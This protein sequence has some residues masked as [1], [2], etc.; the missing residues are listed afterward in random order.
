MISVKINNL[1]TLLILLN[2]PA[3]GFNLGI[4]PSPLRHGCSQYIP[5]S[6]HRCIE[7]STPLFSMI[8]ENDEDSSGFTV[9]QRL[10]EEVE[11]PFRKLRLY[12]FGVSTASALLALYFSL[13][14]ALKASVGGFAD[15]QPLEEALNSCGINVAAVIIC[16]GITYRDVK[17]GTANLE[18]IAKGGALAKLGVLS[19]ISQKPLT[20]S[21]YRR[22]SRVL[23]AVGGPEYIAELARSLNSDQLSD[24]NT[25]ASKIGEVDMVIVPVLLQNENRV[26][27]TLACWQGTTAID[28]RDRNFDISRSDEVLAFPNGNYGWEQYLKSEIETAKKQGFDVLGKGLTLIVKKNGRILRRTTG[29]PNWANFI[30]TMEV[31]DGSKFGMPGDTEKYG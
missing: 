2:F 22:N 30:G 9:K 18:R 11:S 24:N 3:N 16:G 28:G 8:P 21:D 10:R 23:I 4:Y 17:A 14:S 1:W 25:I 15:T 19:P 20:L 29:Q 26:G 6:T 27:N 12:F 31:L 13:I 7:R 5:P